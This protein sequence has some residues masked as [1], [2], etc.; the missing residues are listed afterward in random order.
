MHKIAVRELAYF[1]YQSGNLTN[2]NSFNQKAIDGKYLHQI[3]Q[4]EYDGESQK[5][6]LYS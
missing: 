1:V 2:S 5:R 4:S 3:R 6:I